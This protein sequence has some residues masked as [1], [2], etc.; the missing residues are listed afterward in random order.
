M[1]WVPASKDH[2]KS[3]HPGKSRQSGCTVSKSAGED[4]TMQISAKPPTDKTITLEAEPSDS[5]KTAVTE[6]QDGEW[7]GKAICSKTVEEVANANY[8]LR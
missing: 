2:P 3:L 6:L 5:I 1:A 8:I 4:G 7:D